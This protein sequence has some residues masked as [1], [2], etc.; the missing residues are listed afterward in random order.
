[1][2]RLLPD[3]ACEHPFFAARRDRQE[4][5]LDEIERTFPDLPKVRLS[6]LDRDV[7]G[8]ESLERIVVELSAA[9]V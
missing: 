6:L 4:L 9:I 2:N 8:R 1:M 7:V 3:D 5:Y